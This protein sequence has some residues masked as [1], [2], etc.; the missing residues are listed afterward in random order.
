MSKKI[1]NKKILR[2][3]NRFPDEG[4]VQIRKYLNVSIVS[5]Y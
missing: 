1:F 4:L 5:K 3:P 2:K